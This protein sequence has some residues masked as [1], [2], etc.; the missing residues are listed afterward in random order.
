LDVRFSIW[1]D[2]HLFHMIT[3]ICNYQCHG[4]CN[5]FCFTFMHKSQLVRRHIVPSILLCLYRCLD[6]LIYDT[7]FNH[8]KFSLSFIRHKYIWLL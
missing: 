2:S 6:D 1:Y 7:G 4:I 3:N 8:Q 5:R